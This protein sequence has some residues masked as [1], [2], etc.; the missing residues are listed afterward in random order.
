MAGTGEKGSVFSVLARK[1]EGKC[2]F[3]DL[4]M[5][6]KI[7]LRWILKQQDWRKWTEYIWRALV[8]SKIKYTRFVNCW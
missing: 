4:S 8:G 6:G 2:H 3:Q 5:N 1:C 7:I